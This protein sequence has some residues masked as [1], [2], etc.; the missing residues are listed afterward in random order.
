MNRILLPTMTCKVDLKSNECHVGIIPKRFFL[1]TK[2]VVTGIIFVA[3][4]LLQFGLS[5]QSPTQQ[6]ITILNS[7]NSNNDLINLD[8]GSKIP[9][10]FNSSKTKLGLVYNT[11]G[12]PYTTAL[13]TSDG[14]Q[15]FSNVHATTATAKD[16][17]FDGSDNLYTI[18]HSNTTTT[19]GFFRKFN[20]TGGLVFNNTIN[21][22]DQDNLTSIQINSSNESII[23]SCQKNNSNGYFSHSALAYNSADSL[24]WS[25]T[26]S[27]FDWYYGYA[28]RM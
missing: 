6:W 14:S 28:T 12:Q 8:F 27:D 11:A 1:A 5:A 15:V 26:I 4:C 23:Y 18:A 19:D 22:A 24:L 10:V 7:A 25:S 13:N 16:L 21:N 2:H 20:S 9:F 3:A 17:V